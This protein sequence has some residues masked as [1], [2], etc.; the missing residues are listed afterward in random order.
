VITRT[1]ID[2]I[3]ALAA[4]WSAD[5][6]DGRSLA[7]SAP[8][9]WPTLALLAA[10]STGTTRARLAAAT[11]VDAD[12]AAAAARA[13][14]ELLNEG[15][16][17]RAAIGLWSRAELVLDP[18]WLDELPPYVH[19]VLTGEPSRDKESLDAWIAERTGGLFPGLP[20]GPDVRTRLMLIGT[21]LVTLAWRHP[22][23]VVS[24]NP[25]S[26]PWTPFGGLQSAVDPD[27]I[28]VRKGT[29]TSVVVRGT[30]EVDVHLVLDAPPRTAAEV[31]AT[32]ITSLTDP[33]LW[34]AAE[35]VAPPPGT[36][37]RTGRIRSTTEAPVLRVTAP[38]F[39]VMAAHDLLK[40][41]HVFGLP[42]P[43]KDAP[44]NENQL[45]AASSV[46]LQLDDAAQHV[47]AQFTQHGFT[48]AAVTA[49]SWIPVGRPH[50]PYDVPLTEVVF[51]RPYGFLAVH[52]PTNLVLVAG[53]VANP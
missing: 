5:V 42:L 19:G 9:V 39:K 8:A 14:L 18:F 48:A 27:D 50:T 12:R 20:S 23:S 25:D 34:T 26:G 16:E 46:A 7:L 41:R 1:S 53:W 28:V 13:V 4:R 24:V 10:G 22:M 32:A 31:V 45:R 11:G 29:L 52:R 47:I 21:L 30:G 35:P 36:A 43:H 15:T 51:D 6:L 33:P 37:V 38:R 49:E 17:L 40:R 44:S 2:S 3:N